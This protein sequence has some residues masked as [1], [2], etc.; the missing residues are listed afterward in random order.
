[1]LETQTATQA[2]RRPRHV[3][4]AEPL[5]V[6]VDETCRLGGFGP[7]TCWKLIAEGKLETT[8]IGRR[9]LVLYPS[10]KRLLQPT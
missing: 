6:S 3:Q 4:S 5:A 9:R 2:C 8:K 7:T 10:L 1:M